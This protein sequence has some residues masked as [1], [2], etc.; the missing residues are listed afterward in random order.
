[1]PNK[2]WKI[3][4]SGLL[5]ICLV[6]GLSMEDSAIDQPGLTRHLHA[7]QLFCDRFCLLNHEEIGGAVA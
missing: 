4:F 6:M 2:L 1:M 5:A 3:L 7:L